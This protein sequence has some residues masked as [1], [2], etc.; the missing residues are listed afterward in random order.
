MG[1][2]G[3]DELLKLESLDDPYLPAVGDLFLVNT[4]ILDAV[5]VHPRRPAVV[6]EVPTNLQGRIYVVT[7]TRNLKR[8][9]VTHPPMPSADLHDKG[10]FAY[11]R[12]AEAI[13]WKH[14]HVTYLDV[15]DE[16]TLKDVL[17]WVG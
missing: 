14:E 2:A 8:S 7:R 5:D 13:M 1:R 9:G 11:L 4:A 12:S 16:G 17:E 10:V 6:I 15:L 3:R